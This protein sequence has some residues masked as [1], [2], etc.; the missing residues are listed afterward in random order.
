MPN[1]LA[2]T[3]AYEPAFDII[4]RCGTISKIRYQEESAESMILQ[5]IDFFVP[6][7]PINCKL[8]DLTLYI[9][10]LF[11]LNLLILATLEVVQYL[12]SCN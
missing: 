8:I 9:A 3:G 2:Y 6:K 12:L 1:K 11:F 7:R 4:L 10:D 5:L